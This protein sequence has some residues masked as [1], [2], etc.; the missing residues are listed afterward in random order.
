[1]SFLSFPRSQ[2]DC[3]YENPEKEDPTVYV[4][5]KTGRGPLNEDW[6]DE[7]W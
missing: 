6:I 5:E 3:T 1:M 2:D 7:F 4:S